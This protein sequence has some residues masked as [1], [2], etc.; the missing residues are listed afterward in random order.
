MQ[1][2]LIGLLV[3]AF[4]AVAVSTSEPVVAQAQTGD[5]QVPLRMSA[6]A[7]NLSNVAT[8]ANTIMEIRVTRWTTAD[9]RK[10]LIAAFVEKQ[11]DGL[12]RALQRMPDHGRM[13]IPGWMGNDP[14]NA[15]LGWQLHYAWHMPQ[16]DG[17]HQIVIATDR[18][19]GFWEQRQQPRTIDYPFTFMQIQIGKDGQGEG[20]MAVATKLIFDKGKNTV[21]M[22]NYSTEPVRLNQVKIEKD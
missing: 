4:A 7:V 1:K 13:R 3:A 8:G 9:E 17:G 10:S 22:E 21:I 14:Y 12:L 15:R 5:L 18:Y 16:P 2:H 20:K 11:Q 19:I 6:W